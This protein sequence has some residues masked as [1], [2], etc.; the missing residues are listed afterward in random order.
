MV[1][2]EGA[3]RALESEV[4][5]CTACGLAETRSRVVVGGGKG[6]A[7]VFVVGEAPAFDEDR[8]ADAWSGEAGALF[9]RLL[10]G[11]GVRRSEV[12][13]TTLLKCRPPQTRDPLDEEIAACEPHLFRQIEL[14]GPR[15][16]VTLG[17][18]A[19]RV[20]SGRAHPITQV[21]G[22]PQELTL[23]AGSVTLLPLYHPAVALYTPSMLKT[24]EDDVAQLPALL[25]RG[26]PERAVVPEARADDVPEDLRDVG[27]QQLQLGLF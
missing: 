20:L 10:E 3:L 12:Y 2:S 18:I 27:L 5:A 15:V 14:V 24:L 13:V 21:H 17:T 26:V 1:G 6:G 22:I 11:A 9:L 4:S 7:P 23:G 8:G 25:G 16:V 19:T